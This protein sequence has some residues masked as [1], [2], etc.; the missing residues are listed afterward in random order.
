MTSAV[1]SNRYPDESQDPWTRRD[2]SPRE[3]CSWIPDR[4]RDDGSEKSLAKHVPGDDDAH[5][6]VGALQDR[7]DAKVAP[8]ALDRVI[9]QIAVA[10]VELERPVDDGGAGVGGE[11]LGHRGE[12]RLVGG[13][14]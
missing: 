13:V 5:D 10:A 9:H 2:E 11:A 6:L 4:A 12:A 7:M 1:M 3:P 14:L 8:E